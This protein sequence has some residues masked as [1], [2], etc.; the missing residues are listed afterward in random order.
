VSAVED[1]GFCFFWVS[2]EEV[3]SRGDS[4]ECNSFLRNDL[5]GGKLILEAFK[6]LLH[7]REDLGCSGG[8]FFITWYME[9][10]PGLNEGGIRACSNGDIIIIKGGIKGSCIKILKELEWVPVRFGFRRRD[11]RIGGRSHGMG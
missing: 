7:C 9:V 11:R 4:S 1:K 8:F 10:E 5:N 6:N 3:P 2:R